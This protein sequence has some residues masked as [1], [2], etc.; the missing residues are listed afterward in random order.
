MSENS[1][2]VQLS[3]SEAACLFSAAAN[4]PQE[5]DR[6]SRAGQV[7]MF[8]R[9]H[10]AIGD[11][12]RRA[13]ESH[14]LEI[15][16]RHDDNEIWLSLSRLA[17]ERLGEG[18]PT[19]KE[20]IEAQLAYVFGAARWREYWPEDQLE[21]LACEE[22]ARLAEAKQRRQR[23]NEAEAK[24]IAEY[25]EWQ[26]QRAE[27]LKHFGKRKVVE[28]GEEAGFGMRE[29]VEPEDQ[30][31]MRSPARVSV[32]VA[33]LRDVRV[34]EASL[35]AATAASG[36]MPE[37]AVAKAPVRLA[38]YL[39][40]WSPFTEARDHVQRTTGCSRRDAQKALVMAAQD[41]RIASRNSDT[42]EDIDAKAWFRVM[43]VE[44]QPSLGVGCDGEIRRV[45]LRREDLEKLWPGQTVVLGHAAPVDAASASD[46]N[47][48]RVDG[49]SEDLRPASD[50][51]IHTAITAVYDA[52]EQA[53]EKPPNIRE[54][55]KPVREELRKTGHS[56]SGNQ[57]MRLADDE[58]HHKRR[59]KPG[60]TL[61]SEKRKANFTK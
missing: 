24:A 23:Q 6:L 12:L 40:A 20:G 4:P 59:R 32:R 34:S 41:S 22:G 47:N 37:P 44:G 51:R 21:R 17:C 13:D 38:G 55:P 11:L 26:R 52:A 60:K 30:D 33:T 53:R 54:L 5:F 27:R 10:G 45:E 28:P 8:D 36:Y 61:L 15:T 35:R 58:K 14:A 19:V 18:D 46:D 1:E 25:K 43:F 3:L 9:D 50:P 49:V 2:E 31:A 57:I 39:S 56:A 29:V 16:F 42:G 48:N 7:W